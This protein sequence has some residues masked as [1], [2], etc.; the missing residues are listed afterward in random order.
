MEQLRGELA[1][2]QP[3]KVEWHLAD[4]AALAWADYHRC[5]IERER[6]SVTGH[7]GLKLLVYHD[8]RVDRAH[9]RFIRTLKAMAAVRKLDLTAIQINLGTPP[10]GDDTPARNSLT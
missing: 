2:S 7:D 8:Q 4:A 3:S 10:A 5:V 9:K 1:G 6:L